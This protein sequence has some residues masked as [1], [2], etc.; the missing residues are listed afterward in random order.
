MLNEFIV[1]VHKRKATGNW[2]TS[3]WQI[4]PGFRTQVKLWT[5]NKPAASSKQPAAILENITI[6][7]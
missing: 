6:A 5:G 4:V 2:P 1:Y 7:D 3:F